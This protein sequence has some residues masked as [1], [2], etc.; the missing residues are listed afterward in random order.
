M[1]RRI[2]KVIKTDN[3]IQTRLIYY[4]KLGQIYSIGNREYFKYNSRGLLSEWENIE[5]KNIYKSNK[6]SEEFF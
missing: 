6:V 4:T 5:T 3:S 1:L 2:E